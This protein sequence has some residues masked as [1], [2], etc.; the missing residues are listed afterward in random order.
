MPSVDAII[1]LSGGVDS[2]VLLAEAIAQGKRCQAVSFDYGQ[3]HYQELAAA[4][5]IA[6]HYGVEHL[7]ICLD[8]AAFGAS[9]L[10]DATTSVPTGDELVKGGIPSTYV[11]ARN[12][13]FL[14]Y[15]MGQAELFGAQ[16]IHYAAHADDAAGYPDCRPAFVQ[17]FQALLNVASKQAVE[18][19]APRLVAPFLQM[20]KKEIIRRGQDLQVPFEMTWSCYAPHDDAPCGQ[21]LACTLRQQAFAAAGLQDP[22]IEDQ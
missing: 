13:L 5:D 2:L 20:T 3:R 8:P 11:P 19:Q 18:G 10:L 6:E 4:A 22:A 7:V 16:E 15:A 12:T 1:L 9:T 21:C 17:A 14:A